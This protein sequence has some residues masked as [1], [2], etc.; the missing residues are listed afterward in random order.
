MK[1]VVRAAW[2]K[3]PGVFSLCS[4]GGW[5]AGPMT[6]PMERRKESGDGWKRNTEM[7][8]SRTIWTGAS[9]RSSAIRCME[10]VP[11]FPSDVEFLEHC[12]ATYQGK[13]ERFLCPE[14]EKAFREWAESITAPQFEERV[15]Q[16]RGSEHAERFTD[17]VLE[18][19]GERDRRVEEYQRLVDRIDDVLEGRAGEFLTGSA[20]LR[21]VRGEDEKSPSA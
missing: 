8:S 16:S 20:A 4:N 1:T 10:V 21:W 9:Q 3:T 14:F 18:F 12:R 17:M 11:L 13:I 6:P 19:E 2:E 5:G 15:M 7:K